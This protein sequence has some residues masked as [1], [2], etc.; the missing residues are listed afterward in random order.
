MPLFDQVFTPGE[1]VETTADN[2]LASP[3]GR[4]ETF[5]VTF[6]D[7]AADTELLI[8]TPTKTPTRSNIPADLRE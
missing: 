1:F 6:V 2:F 7:G 4:D 5:H 8:V 3:A